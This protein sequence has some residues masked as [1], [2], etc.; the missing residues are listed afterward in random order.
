MEKT[1]KLG[2]IKDL[3]DFRDYSPASEEETV[4]EEGNRLASIRSMLNRMSIEQHEANMLVPA[5]FSLRDAFNEIA[6]EDQGNLNSCTANAG[7]AL[8]EY[9]EKKAFGKYID[10]SRLFL[11]KTTRNLLQFKGDHGA[12]IRTTIGAM[13]LFGVLPEKYWQYQEAKVDE[14]P[15]AFCYAFAQN[16]KALSYYRLDTTNVSTTDLLKRVK[17][18][19]FRGLPVMFGFTVF[20]SIR[21]A[22][23]NGGIIPF[24]HKKE[25]A[26]GGHAVVALGY[27]DEKIMPDKNGGSTKGAILIRN[28]WGT[29]GDE[30]YGWIP[31]AYVSSGMATDWWS[32]LKN[33][34]VDTGNF[35]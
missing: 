23:S 20:Q 8:L 14:E 2:W 32:L 28:S 30:G 3:A 7:I 9:F 34:W 22:K 12:Y 5:A 33:D 31:Y 15:S 11:Y 21:D 25:T 13:R 6:I 26:Q 18:Y 24:P 27:D 19:I 1:P 29:W 10:A 17:Y 4:S 35:S 16:Y